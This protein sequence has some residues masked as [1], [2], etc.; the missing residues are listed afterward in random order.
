[1]SADDNDNQHGQLLRVYELKGG[2]GLPAPP[3]E[4]LAGVWPQ[5]PYYYLFYREEVSGAVAAWLAENPAWRLTSRYTLPY[6][7]WQDVSEKV[8]SVGP[9]TIRPAACQELPRAQTFAIPIRID[10]G[11]VFGSGLHPTTKGCL[12]AISRLF[13]QQAPNAGIHPTCG[14]G[15]LER[16]RDNGLDAG[17]NHLRGPIRTVVDFGAGTGILSVACAL[18]GA[19]RAWAIDCIP[20]ALPIARQNTLE[21]GTAGRIGFICADRL[22]VLNISSDL[23]L[24]NIEWPVLEEVLRG[25]T[26]RRHKRVILSG[27]LE[28]MLDRVEKLVSPWYVIAGRIILEGWPTVTLVR[29]RRP[30]RKGARSGDRVVEFGHFQAR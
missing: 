8:L 6:D 15:A 12:L 20:F 28:G 3:V 19:K 18:L 16:F 9:F 13:A 17:K 23:L 29:K 2:K 21:N 24:M 10:P 4:G 1:M 5:P 11:V 25:E 30:T 14:E 7:K 26:W 27:F 22:D